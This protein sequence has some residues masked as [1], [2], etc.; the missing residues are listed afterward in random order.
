MTIK[1]G[2][3]VRLNSGGPDMIMLAKVVEVDSVVCFWRT[4]Y[5]ASQHVFNRHCL[6][7]IKSALEAV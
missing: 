1:K 2:D 6:T 7:K 3:T 5:G 4:Q